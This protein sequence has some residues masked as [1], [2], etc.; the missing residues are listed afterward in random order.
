MKYEDKIRK[1]RNV[2]EKS[3]IYI[4][5]LNKKFPQKEIFNTLNEYFKKHGGKC[6]QD[7]RRKKGYCVIYICGTKFYGNNSYKNN[8]Y[9]RIV[10]EVP[11]DF[12]EKCLVLGYLPRNIL[13]KLKK[14]Q[15]VH[16]CIV[17]ML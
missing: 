12:I 6:K 11:N 10:L 15:S 7:L 3:E 13:T 8:I 2:L 14:I 16:F 9:P 17:K 5:A 1:F 4:K